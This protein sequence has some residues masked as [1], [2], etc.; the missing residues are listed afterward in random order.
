[1][2]KQSW[3]GRI[4]EILDR[5]DEAVRHGLLPQERAIAV[6][7]RAEARIGLRE[8]AKSDRSLTIRRRYQ[9]R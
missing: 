4:S 8:L 3:K 1:M 2:G 7:E 6:K 5:V 9:R